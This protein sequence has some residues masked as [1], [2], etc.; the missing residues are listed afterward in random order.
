MEIN[1]ELQLILDT[2]LSPFNIRCY[3]KKR[4]DS[5][6][7]EYVIYD[8]VSAP[9]TGYAN[10]LPTLRR[11]NVDVKYYATKKSFKHERLK[12]IGNV[13]RENGWLV[14]APDMEIPTLEETELVGYAIE[15]N[16]ELVI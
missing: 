11:Y 10:N 15:F 4:G 13:M 16:K 9:Y 12:V 1:G 8:V 6:G 3:N 5:S 7:K 14:S 2:A